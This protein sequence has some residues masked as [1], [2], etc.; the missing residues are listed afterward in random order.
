MKESC[1]LHVL[2]L[3]NISYIIIHYLEEYRIENETHAMKKRQD[4]KIHRIRMG[5][6]LRKKFMLFVSKFTS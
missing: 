1:R 2:I 4:I 6:I 5:S 3:F